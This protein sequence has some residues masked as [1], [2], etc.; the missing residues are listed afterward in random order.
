MVSILLAIIAL[1]VLIMIHEGGHFLVA[2]LSGMRVDRFSIGFGPALLKLKRGE[3]VY[4]VG[5]IPLGGFVQIAGL[6]PNEEGMLADDPRSYPKRPVYQRFLTIAAGPVTNYVF[7]A[8]WMGVVFMLFGEPGVGKLPVVEDL[9][10]GKPAAASGMQL[11]DEVISIDARPVKK[12]EDVSQIIESAQGKP[13]VVAVLRGGTERSYT[14]TPAQSDGHWRIGIQIMARQEWFPVPKGQAF[15]D[16]VVFPFRM[17]PVILHELGRLVKEF[18]PKRMSGPIGMVTQLR[19]NIKHGWADGLA[20][21]GAISV[22]LGLFNLL[23]LP[24]L[25]GGRLIF[26]VYEG[27]SRRRFPQMIEQRIHTVGI[28]AL[29]G[30]LLVISVYDIIRLVH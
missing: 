24:A 28:L 6:N 19:G 23:P 27:V 14:I 25:D 12:M 7:A 5:A 10:T 26:L 3:T 11:G 30:L 9:V 4:Q 2:R 1:G 20:T 17:T 8:V 22:G 21:I 13:V 16:G 18:S 15:V 29:L